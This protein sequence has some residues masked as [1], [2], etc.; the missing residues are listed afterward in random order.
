M[1]KQK[2]ITTGYQITREQAHFI[3]QNDLATPAMASVMC[4]EYGQDDDF[5]EV[6][7][8]D[9]DE[10][11]LELDEDYKTLEIWFEPSSTQ[12][13]RRKLIEAAKIKV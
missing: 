10:E 13:Q 3:L 8:E 5:E 11:T 9:L 1:A 7:E 6:T 4:K 2:E 12:A